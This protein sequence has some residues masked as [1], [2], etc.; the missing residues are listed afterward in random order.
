[1]P[2][3]DLRGGGS[4]RGYHQGQSELCHP[5]NDGMRGAVVAGVQD[6]GRAVWRGPLTTDGGNTAS[7]QD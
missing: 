6:R 4:H 3:G 1:M 5:R 2:L 7:I